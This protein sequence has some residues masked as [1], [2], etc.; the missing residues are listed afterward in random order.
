MKAWRLV[1]GAL[2]AIV[3]SFWQPLAMPSRCTQ[4]GALDHRRPVGEF[5]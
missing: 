5:R 4:S 1:Q 3:R 2:A